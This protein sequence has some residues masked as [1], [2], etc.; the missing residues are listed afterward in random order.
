[1]IHK[2]YDHGQ[3]TSPVSSSVSLL[4]SKVRMTLAAQ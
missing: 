4:V 3:V 2:G 1:M